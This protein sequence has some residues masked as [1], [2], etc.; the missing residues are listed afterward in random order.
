VNIGRLLHRAEGLIIVDAR[1]LGEPSK[2]PVSLVSFQ[3][4]VGVKLALEDPFA[5]DNVRT[6]MPRN[7]IPGV[8]GD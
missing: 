4:A 7:K 3:C 8:V 1:P 6:S 5:S 2:D